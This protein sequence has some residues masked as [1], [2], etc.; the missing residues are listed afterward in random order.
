VTNTKIHRYKYPRPSVTVD[1][2]L[3]G[4]N[5]KS[6]LS[7]LLIRRR[8]SP[9]QGAWALP[10]GFVNVSDTPPYGEGLEDAARRELEEETGAKVAHLEQLSTFGTPDRDPRGRVI[11][12]AYMGLVRTTDHVVQGGDDAAEAEW[13]AETDIVT[14]A[15]DHKEILRVAC[16]R[17]AAKVRYAPIGFNLLPKEFTLSD[18]QRVYEAVL[19]EPLDKRNF[20]SRILAMKILQEAG[21]Q[22]G[23]RHRPGMLYRFDK[24]AYDTAVRDGFHFE[25]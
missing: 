8:D 7:V 13:I 17:L 18:L 19:R 23:T 6:D 2:V 12:V 16:E 11:S 25:I 10:G 14:L 1:C 4:I 24:R 20:R 3:F 9:F 22:K 15:F 21:L 5:P